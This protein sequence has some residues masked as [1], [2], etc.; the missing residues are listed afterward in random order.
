[1]KRF[2]FVLLLLLALL[3]SGCKGKSIKDISVTSVRLV[4]I[5]PEGLT[6]LS[7]LV[8]VGIHNPT[9]G[10][11]LF[12]IEGLARYQGQDA[13]SAKADQLVVSGNTDKLY[14]IPVQGQ[15]AEGF[16]PFQLLKLFGSESTFDDVTF[17]VRGKVAL[18]G[19][20]GKNIEI[21]DIPL[22]QF[23]NKEEKNEVEQA[24]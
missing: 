11:E 3:L 6:G 12:D 17:T 23:F 24:Q 20:V 7:A 1:M 16:N 8:E 15:I 5:V 19:G 10:F 22:S 2:H 18:R 21:K 13:F 14:R 9:V 4:S